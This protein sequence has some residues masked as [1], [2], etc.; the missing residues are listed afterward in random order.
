MWPL[1]TS[2]QASW[3]YNSGQNFHFVPQI[4]AAES[5]AI[6]AERV[7][8]GAGRGVRLIAKIKELI[9]RIF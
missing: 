8:G 9:E 4:F 7:A 3:R 5:E 1:A 6:A 2:L